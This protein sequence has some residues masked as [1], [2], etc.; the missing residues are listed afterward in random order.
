MEP[1][2][3]ERCD[4]GVNVVILDVNSTHG[5]VSTWIS[6]QH[7]IASNVLMYGRRQG[8]DDAPSERVGARA[9]PVSCTDFTRL[10]PRNG[11]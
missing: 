2:T 5:S 4:I 1:Q 3:W 8:R 9:V 11:C 7:I 6:L 10:V